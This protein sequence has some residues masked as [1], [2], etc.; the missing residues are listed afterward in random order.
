M[1]KMTLCLLSLLVLNACASRATGD[2]PWAKDLI[3]KTGYLNQRP[4]QVAILEG[5]YTLC[6]PIK[7]LGFQKILG[8]AIANF[9]QESGKFNMNFDI[10]EDGQ[11]LKDLPDIFVED[12]R[13]SNARVKGIQGKPTRKELVCQGNVFMGMTPQ[14]FMVVVGKP[15]SI[16]RTVARGGQTEQWV[17]QNHPK[18]NYYYFR[19]SILTSW[20]D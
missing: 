3:G 18:A 15:D 4:R 9:G 1:N 10:S 8:T 7:I 6:A 12:L 11:K 19:N 5:N 16:N 20:Q 17:Y 13:L 2:E 14:E